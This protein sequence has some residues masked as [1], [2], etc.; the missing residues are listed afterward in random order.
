M[1]HNEIPPE[2]LK[3]IIEL[4]TIHGPKYTFGMH[5]KEDMIQEAIMMGIDA[6]GRWDRIRPLENFLCIHIS[7]RL[8]TFKRDNFFRATGGN[9]KR[10]NFKRDL[11]EG[12]HSEPADAGYEQDLIE[13]IFTRDQIELIEEII[14]ARLRRNL[15]RLKHGAKL[16]FSKKQ[17]IIEF[18]RTY[19]GIR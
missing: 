18:L 19:F 6:Y 8:K 9:E 16:E 15:L 17:E 1:E 5:E 10:Q 14:P 2:H 12:S 4:A 13:P 7:N 11:A 3:R